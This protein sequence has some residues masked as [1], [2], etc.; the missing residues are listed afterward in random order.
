MFSRALRSEGSCTARTRYRPH[1][2][3]ASLQPTSLHGFAPW[4]SGRDRASVL[5]LAVN[6]RAVKD[7]TIERRFRRYG[8]YAGL[9][10]WLVLTRD[11]IED[12]EGPPP[13][14]A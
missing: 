8:P 14:V 3:S 13:V 12:D 2:R 7:S 6:G 1:S 5:L 11:W 9:A 10:F 4:L